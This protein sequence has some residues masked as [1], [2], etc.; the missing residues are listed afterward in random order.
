MI[1]ANYYL[2]I[3]T[4]TTNC[5]VSLF[6]GNELLANKETNSGY[7]HIE[8]LA[9][10][11]K[12][13]L[14]ESAIGVSDLSGIG[15][16][17]GPGSYTGLR[18]GVSFVKGLALSSQIPIVSF[19]SLEL[20]IAKVSSIYR[21]NASSHVYIP[22][23]DARRMEVYCQ[24]YDSDFKPKSE[25]FAE[26]LTQES[27]MGYIGSDTPVCFF[28]PG[29]DKYLGVNNSV[30]FEHI[31]NVYPSSKDM[32]SLI[33][34]KISKGMVMD[35]AYFEPFYLKNF[36]AGKPKRLILSPE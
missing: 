21:N 7:S 20:M 25:V 23:I 31:S 9:V 18:I 5:S 8:N 15:V 35:L 10:D 34:S 22:M 33:E 17:V 11:T 28:G 1:K 32:S 6:K 26:V 3:E 24:I 27:F 36:V 19:T 2:G 4:S 30:E 16:G 12:A 13:I 29:S 14:V